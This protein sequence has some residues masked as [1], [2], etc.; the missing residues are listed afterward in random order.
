LLANQTQHPLEL[1]LVL[2][3]APAAKAPPDRLTLALEA[4]LPLGIEADRQDRGDIVGPVLEQRTSSS[5][6]RR[7]SS[8]R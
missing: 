8:G 2:L 7:S 3:A 1:I 4:Q 6:A 5:S